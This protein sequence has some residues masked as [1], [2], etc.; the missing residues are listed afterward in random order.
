MDKHLVEQY[1][2]DKE[3]AG[4]IYLY[5]SQLYKHDIE[6]CK[7]LVDMPFDTMSLLNTDSVLFGDYETINISLDN[8]S[9]DK[10]H[11]VLLSLNKK[12][13]NLYDI[14][15]VTSCEGGLIGEINFFDKEAY[16]TVLKW[17]A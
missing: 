8:L 5:V 1:K 14:I 2:T 15:A 10:K 13:D 17:I 16:E 3:V 11:L 6:T 12:V 7:V 9:I 4:I